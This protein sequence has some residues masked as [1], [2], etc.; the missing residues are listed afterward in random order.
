MKSIFRQESVYN[1]INNISKEKILKC[2]YQIQVNTVK[3]VSLKANKHGP[4][5]TKLMEGHGI[6]KYSLGYLT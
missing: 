5:A 6:F 2:T 3:L 4:Q 1:P